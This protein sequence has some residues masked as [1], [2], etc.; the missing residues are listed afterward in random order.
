M[1]ADLSP[2][3][4]P[5][6]QGRIPCPQGGEDR[7]SARWLMEQLGYE[8]WQK[9]EG[10]IERAKHTAHSEGFNVRILFKIV[11]KDGAAQVFTGS[12]KNPGGRPGT[13]YLVARYAAYLIAMNGDPRKPQV[14]AAQHYFAVKTRE[15][16]VVAAPTL[17][18]DE[19]VHRALTITQQRVDALT[20]KVVELTAP[21]SAWNE[22]AESAGDYSVADA[23]KVLSRDPNIS[24]G[25]RRLFHAMSGLGWIF[26]RDGRWRAYQAQ[27]E[28]GRLVE[29]VAKPFWHEGR[30]EMVAGEPSVRITPK[31]LAE[32]HRRLGGSG[33]LALVAV[34]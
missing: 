20:A 7:W 2:T 21:A 19:I 23:A 3:G 18:D 26:K 32:L 6:D 12:D 11:A 8:S 9:F 30:S 17:S 16:E 24:T 10:V 13:D 14:A 15:A 4:S 28:C 25:E 27:V 33:Q 31:G 29:K 34:S 1:T 5:F 22:L